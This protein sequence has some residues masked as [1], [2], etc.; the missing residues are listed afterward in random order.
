MLY[1]ATGNSVY[2]S[3]DDGG[4]WTPLRNGMPPAPVHWLTVQ[5]KFNDLV[6]ATYGRGIWVMDDITPLREYDTAK[7]RETYLFKPKASYR[8]RR[9]SAVRASEGGAGLAG[10]NPPYGADLNFWLKAATK[11]VTLSIIG[12]DNKPVRTLKVQGRAGLNRV[13]WDLRYGPSETARLRTPPPDA[14]WVKN[15]PEGWRPVVVIYLN[16]PRDPEP[17]PLV[18]PG[19]YTVRLQVGGHEETAPL[20]I[21][22]DPHSL[23][24][25]A[26]MQE[27]VTFALAVLDELSEAARLINVIEWEKKQ[28]ADLQEMLGSTGGE[29]AA[30]IQGARDLYQKILSVEEQ[31]VDVHLTGVREDSLRNPVRLYDRLVKFYDAFDGRIGSG[32]DAADLGPTAQQIAVNEIFKKQ[33]AELQAQFQALRGKDIASFNSSLKQNRL[34]IQIQP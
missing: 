16:D 24:T 23:G 34:D 17:G 12:A 19:A 26:T 29:H 5:P 10:Q 13:W 9:D 11:D 33:L 25:P 6:V 27:Q 4:H 2:V 18:A 1:L 20:Q 15:G 30:L 8:F 7:Q 32:G 21:L 3:W 31:L 14:P 22:P 28:L